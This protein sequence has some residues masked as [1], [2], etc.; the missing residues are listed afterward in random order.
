LDE[1]GIVDEGDG[2]E[3]CGVLLVP[4]EKVPEGDLGSGGDEGLKG[5]VVRFG[6]AAITT[7]ETDWG[8]DVL[9]ETVEFGIEAR[10]QGEVRGGVDSASPLG[11]PARGKG[12]V[13]IRMVSAVPGV[14]G[15][16]EVFN[17]A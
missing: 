14:E 15:R 6:E 17:G 11:Q 8:S 13:G 12:P 5:R 4:E 10:G 9:L 2:L 16:Y 1:N 3:G 7:N